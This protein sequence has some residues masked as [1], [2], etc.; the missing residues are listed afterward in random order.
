MSLPELTE[1]TSPDR[2]ELPGSRGEHFLQCALETTDRATRFYQDQ[3]LD[4]LN[5]L[6]MGFVAKMEMAFISTADADGE[7]D[8]SLRAGPAGFLRALDSRTLVYPEYRGNGVMASL[9]NIM[10]NPHVGMLMVDFTEDLIGLHVNGS[11]RIAPFEEF[12]GL[13]SEDDRKVE[14]WVVVTV[15]E[16]YIH[17]RKHIPRM[18]PVDRIRDWGTDD[19]R[20]KGG[21]FFEA[22]AGRAGRADS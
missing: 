4:H 7:C 3:V 20:R 8:S 1:T 11:A 22:K 17:C 9:G 2:V 19:V 10:E 12:A 14:R 6:M 16:A 21:D 15:R 5:P 13:V 18:V